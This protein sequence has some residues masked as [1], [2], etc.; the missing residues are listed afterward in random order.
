[1]TEPLE[2]YHRSHD[3]ESVD[4]NDLLNTECLDM[5][6]EVAWDQWARVRVFC[7][8]GTAEGVSGGLCLNE[9]FQQ[10]LKSV[11]TLSH[12]AVIC[13]ADCPV[14]PEWVGDSHSADDMTSCELFRGHDGDHRAFHDDTGEYGYRY[15]RMQYVKNG[16]DRTGTPVFGSTTIPH[17][18][19][20]YMKKG[21]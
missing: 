6:V 18:Y 5:S 21:E 16:V 19:L 3:G 9:A 14:P 10:A 1:M 20:K 4:L 11:S 8:H 13:Y 12:D 17:P 7:V 15:E 2:Y